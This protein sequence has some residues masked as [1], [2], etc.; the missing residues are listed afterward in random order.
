ML[1][2]RVLVFGLAKEVAMWQEVWKVLAESLRKWMNY[3]MSRYERRDEEET[4]DRIEFSRG[5]L[6]HLPGDCV[7]ASMGLLKL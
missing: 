5:L 2:L 6:S 1:V 4:R 7:Q 3:V